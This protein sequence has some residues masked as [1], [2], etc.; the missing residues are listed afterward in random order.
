MDEIDAWLINELNSVTRDATRHLENYRINEAT[1]CIYEFFW[2]TFCDWYVEIIKDNFNQLKAKTAIYTLINSIKLLHPVM[3]FITEEVFHL[4]KHNLSL[5]LGE[6]ISKASWPS[7]IEIPATGDI[8][9]IN[10]LFETIKEIRNIK[11]DLGI[12]QKKV[13]LQIKTSRENEKY[14]SSHE[15]WVKRLAYLQAFEFTAAP[16]RVIY[17]NALWE[18]NL[19]IE[20]INIKDFVSTL[21]KKI[22]NLEAVKSKVSGRLNNENFLKNASLETVEEEKNKSRE[23]DLQLN[24]LK[25]LKD[26]FR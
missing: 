9:K 10:T 5:E 24:R 22:N 6:S 8:K 12:A 17:K 1:K 2:H 18:L 7:P 3:P 15:G 23:I 14:L 21:D 11:A 16:K 13:K 19:D 25:E 26:A 20:E 4:V